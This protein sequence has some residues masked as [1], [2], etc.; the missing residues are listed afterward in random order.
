MLVISPLAA[1]TPPQHEVATCTMTSSYSFFCAD[2]FSLL[3]SLLRI[4]N[5]FFFF[6][7]NLFRFNPFPP[8]LNFNYLIIIFHNLH[9]PFPTT[10]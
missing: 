7:F 6:F 1:H 8:F 3:L 4:N 9:A 5:N 10:E 2:I